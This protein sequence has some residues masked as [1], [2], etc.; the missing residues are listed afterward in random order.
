MK[1]LLLL[2]IAVAVGMWVGFNLAK[3]NDPFA[4]PFDSDSVVDQLRDSGET[5]LK[6][7]GSAL[8]KGID[9]ISK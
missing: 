4:N 5:L 7:G 2:A 9:Q 8:K 3:G 6:D 1:K